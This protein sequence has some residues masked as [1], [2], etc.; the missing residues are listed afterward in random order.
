M[1]DQDTIVMERLSVPLPRGRRKGHGVLVVRQDVV[2]L[3]P[4][5]PPGELEDPREEAE[6]LVDAVVVARD[7]TLP[8]DVILHVCGE[9]L[10][11]ECLHVPRRESVE[12]LADQILVRMS[13]ANL[14]IAKKRL[15]DCR[16]ITL[17]TAN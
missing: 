16:T 11:P 2:K 4:E 15:G 3:D 7:G 5:R 13:H 8:R 10:G 1:E 6:H 9:E 17:Q 14:P 12:S